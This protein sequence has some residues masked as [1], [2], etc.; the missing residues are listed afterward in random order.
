MRR[1]PFWFVAMIVVAPLLSAAPLHK[2]AGAVAGRYIVTLSPDY[3]AANHA[4]T[5]SRTTGATLVHTYDTVLNG[6]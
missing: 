2:F 6:F 1:V 4:E 5:M 3:P